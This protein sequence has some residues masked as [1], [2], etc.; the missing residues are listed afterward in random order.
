ML[1]TKSRDQ[2]KR[3]LGELRQQERIYMVGARRGAR[4]YA[5]PG[6]SGDMGGNGGERT[7]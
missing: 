7:Q 3:M 1:P 2:I 4:W 5:G 6:S